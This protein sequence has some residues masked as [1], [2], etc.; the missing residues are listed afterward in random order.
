MFLVAETVIEEQQSQIIEEIPAVLEAEVVEAVIETTEEPLIE[1]GSEGASIIDQTYGLSEYLI[2]NRKSKESMQEQEAAV[3]GTHFPTVGSYEETPDTPE[4]SNANEEELYSNEELNEN[5]YNVPEQD[6]YMLE[7]A[8][9]DI[10]PPLETNTST[11]IQHE[12]NVIEEIEVNTE[13]VDMDIEYN[14][15]MEANHAEILEDT[16]INHKVMA[17]V[18]MNVPIIKQRPTKTTNAGM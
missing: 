18:N 16:S 15:P 17:S 13:V 2:L 5:V 11:P 1:E 7:I 10:T 4:Y 14:F 3:I 6:E 8:E 12:L 9:S